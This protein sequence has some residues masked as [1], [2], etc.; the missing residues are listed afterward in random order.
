[1]RNFWSLKDIIKKMNKQAMN[2]GG[3]YLQT[4]YLTK[5]GYPE[6]IKNSYG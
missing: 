4:I 5:D 1:M 3:K 6:Y 2:W